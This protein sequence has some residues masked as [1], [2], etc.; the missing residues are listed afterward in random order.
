MT[1]RPDP[2]V[3]ALAKWA[4]ENAYL[5]CSG[6]SFEVVKMDAAS[7]LS[8]IDRLAWRE[9]TGTEIADACLSYRHDFGLMDG[10]ERVALMHQAREWL[11]AWRKTMMPPPPPAQKGEGK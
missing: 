2:R 9:P 6:A 8:D 3:E 10:P 11:H 1:A 4:R 5:Y 7:I